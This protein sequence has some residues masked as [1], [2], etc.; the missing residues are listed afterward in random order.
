[1][2]GV[3]WHRPCHIKLFWQRSVSVYSVLITVGKVPV[4][5]S[6][7]I[8]TW[9]FAGKTFLWFVCVVGRVAWQTHSSRSVFRC[10]VSFI[11]YVDFETLFFFPLLFVCDCRPSLCVCSSVSVC[12]RPM[13]VCLS[14][15]VCAF[16]CLSLCVRLS[17]CLSV[18]VCA[19]VCRLS[20]CVRLSVVCLCTCVFPLFR[21]LEKNA[22]KIAKKGD[23]K[24]W[25]SP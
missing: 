21:E 10:F 13:F 22:K 23:R 17:V 15:S 14:V 9:L 25:W 2:S 12:T 18:S 16:V 3:V 4:H 19:F 5:F 20:L 11:T 1:M 7:E 8:H 6:G 24:K